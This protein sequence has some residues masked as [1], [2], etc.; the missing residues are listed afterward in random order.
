MNI[1]IKTIPHSGQRYPTVGDWWWEE[2]G[3]LEVRVSDMGNPVYEW[4]V[5]EHEIN[6]ALKCKADGVVEKVVS[7]FD[8]RF[9][10]LREQYPDIIGDQEPGDMVSAPYHPQHIGATQ[11][12]KF[13]ASFHGVNWDDYNSTVDNL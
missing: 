3:D 9:E 12:E 11:I 7:E 2:N 4:L 5:A 1:N 6:E 10:N 13:S 8:M